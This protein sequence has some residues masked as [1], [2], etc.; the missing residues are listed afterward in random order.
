[1]QPRDELWNHANSQHTRKPLIF[2]SYRQHSKGRT[3]HSSLAKPLEQLDLS[4]PGT[5]SQE[6]HYG[7]TLVS[8]VC[9]KNYPYSVVALGAKCNRTLDALTML[10]SAYSDVPN[11]VVGDHHTPEINCPL[12][13]KADWHAVDRLIVGLHSEGFLDLWTRFGISDENPFIRNP[14]VDSKV[15][16]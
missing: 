10:Q 16:Q 7:I 11:D 2:L 15:V 8:S 1:V 4:D 3:H 12:Q 5:I 13:P 6:S 9:L 14:S